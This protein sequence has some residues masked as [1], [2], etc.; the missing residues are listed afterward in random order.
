MNV[1]DGLR[2]LGDPTGKTEADWVAALKRS[3]VSIS[4]MPGGMR[5]LRWR[6]G[7]YQIQQVA[8]LFDANYRFVQ[9]THRYG[10]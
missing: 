9:I 3:P 8:V 2:R 1:M 10:C 6:S 4:A 5:L 7:R